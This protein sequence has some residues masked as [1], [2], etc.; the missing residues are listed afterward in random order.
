MLSYRNGSKGSILHVFTV[1][2]RVS[3][4]LIYKIML[5]IGSNNE[6]WMWVAIE[7]FH[8]ILG[9]YISTHSI[10]IIADAFLSLLSKMCGKHIVCS[11]GDVTWYPESCVSL[12][13]EHRLSSS[14]E[15]N[16]VV[17]RTIEYLKDRRDI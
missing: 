1:V 8:K 11:D 9:V 16:I 10:M 17:E 13:L 15:K 14:Y 4:F 12:N 5:Q 3:A 2:K 6:S 7:S